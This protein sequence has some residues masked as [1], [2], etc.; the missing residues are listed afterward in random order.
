MIA[1]MIAILT[2]A[3]PTIA[4]PTIAILTMAIPMI[5]LAPAFTIT[6]DYCCLD[7]FSCVDHL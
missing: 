1:I 3:I 7:L 2:I 5:A 4:I 6:F